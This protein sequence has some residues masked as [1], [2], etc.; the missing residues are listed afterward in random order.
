VACQQRCVSAIEFDTSGGSGRRR[1]ARRASTSGLPSTA[2]VTR[3]S[4]FAEGASVVELAAIMGW[5]PSTAVA[6]SMRYGHPFA[7]RDE[8]LTEAVE[9]VYRNAR[10]PNDGQQAMKLGKLSEETGL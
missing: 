2:S 10:R 9:R 3:R 5:A 1:S 4:R 7:S 8:H 6:M